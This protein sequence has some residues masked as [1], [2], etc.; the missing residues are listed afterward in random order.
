LFWKAG[1]RVLIDGLVV[2]GSAKTV[3]VL[4]GVVRRVQSGYLYHYAFAMVIGL[5]ALI[6]WF[7]VR[8]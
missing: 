2:N 4:A 7:V 5:A 3:A 6:G 1:D 8:S